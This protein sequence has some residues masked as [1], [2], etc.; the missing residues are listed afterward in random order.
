MKPIQQSI[1]RLLAERPHKDTELYQ[2]FNDGDEGITAN[3]CGKQDRSKL[4]AWLKRHVKPLMRERKVCRKS[5]PQG[6]RYEIAEIEELKQVK[7]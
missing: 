6:V 2:H 5:S 7:V 1:L 3:W 4:D